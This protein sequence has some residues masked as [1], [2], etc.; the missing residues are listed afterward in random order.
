MHD[1]N[2]SN[3]H[4]C[5]FA[6]LI[7]YRFACRKPFIHKFPQ[8]RYISSTIHIF[9]NLVKAQPSSPI[10]Y[11]PKPQNY[12]LIFPL[13][14]NLSVEPLRI[15]HRIESSPF[16]DSVSILI[17]SVFHLQNHFELDQ[18][19]LRK[20][21]KSILDTHPCLLFCHP[22]VPSPGPRLPCPQPQQQVAAILYMPPPPLT[23]PSHFPASSHSSP[24]PTH[25][26][27]PMVG[28]L[29]YHLTSGRFLVIQLPGQENCW[30]CQ[31]P[32]LGHRVS[33][34]RLHGRHQ[35]LS[36]HTRMTSHG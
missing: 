20:A 30:E 4:F 14:D 21:L 33:F 24:P 9:T 2:L 1:F 31:S 35:W 25:V 12:N 6:S 15:C 7:H 28:I 8:S 36:L 5:S 17:K 32:R 19:R 29:L 16:F 34:W 22:H 26:S 11:S 10:R 27:P 23:A 13:L 18:F 3:S